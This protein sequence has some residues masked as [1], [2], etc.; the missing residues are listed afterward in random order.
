[1]HPRALSREPLDRK[2]TTEKGG[3]GCPCARWRPDR[4]AAGPRSRFSD[5]PHTPSTPEPA[6]RPHPSPYSPGS[7]R[8]GRTTRSGRPCG[9]DLRRTACSGARRSS[10]LG[11]CRRTCRRQLTQRTR[12]HVA[13][14]RAESSGRLRTR[15][16]RG[17][18][19][20]TSSRSIDPFGQSLVGVADGAQLRLAVGRE[21]T[22]RERP[23]R[24][25][26]DGSQLLPSFVDAERAIQ[27][28]RGRGLGVTRPEA[29]ACRSAEQGRLGGHARPT[30]AGCDRPDRR[31][32]SGS[33]ERERRSD[34]CWKGAAPRFIARGGATRPT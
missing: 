25:S 27:S 2:R 28:H 33:C 8:L 1:M 3:T 19:C 17:G 6:S 16:R 7:Y 4:A 29:I 21:E 10:R 23:R 24:S 30:W 13:D 20:V 14:L 18:G 15:L 22:E 31:R 11:K 34:G 26:G 12:P 5:E 32:L 9:L